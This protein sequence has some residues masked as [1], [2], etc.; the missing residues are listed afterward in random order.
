MDPKVVREATKALLLGVG[1]LSAAVT[2]PEDVTAGW[3]LYCVT[4]G[5]DRYCTFLNYPQIPGGTYC[6]VNC[7][8]GGICS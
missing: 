3:C 8:Y 6:T 7:A 2:E 4:Q 5:D 1:A